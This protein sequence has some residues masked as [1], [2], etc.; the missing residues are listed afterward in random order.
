MTRRVV[1]TGL[2]M[3][4]PLGVTTDESWQGLIA[5]KSGIRTIQR[6]VDEEFAGHKLPVSIGGEVPN[7][8]PEPWLE[9]KKDVKRMDRFILLS[10]CAG[11]QAW[12]QAGLPDRL[13]DVTGNRAGSIVGVGLGGLGNIL[14]AYDNFKEKGPRR[15]SAFFIP[16]IIANLAPGQMAIRY[17][18]RNANWAPASACSSGNHGIGEAF[19]HIRD[20]RADLMLCG[21]AESALEPL[22]VAGFASM[23]ALCTS[24][25]NDPAGSSRPF[26]KTR[27]GF[28]MGEGAGMLVL[29]DLDSAKKRGAKIIAEVAGYGSSDDAN[30]ITAPAP[31]GE[32]A[33]RAIKDALAMAQLNPEQI[34]YVNAHGT[35]TPYND[36]S[37]TDAIKGVF[38]DYA[39][40]LPVSSTK[41]MIG[42]LLGAAG[43]VEAV[44]SILALQHG[45]LPPTINYKEPDPECDL[46]YIPNTAREV[47]VD[48]AISN[49]F[50]FGG[51]NAVLC[52]KQ[53]KG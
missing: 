53:F 51:T 52:F 36:K 23:H 26:D 12:K 6:W 21:G 38:K 18:L 13:D 3:T 25:N 15:V 11:H 48:A 41:S 40:K 1:V 33:Q 7:F 24:K 49:S 27:D 44:I 16:M 2:G 19:M 10:M 43:G 5:G 14:A 46:D 22:A 39:K 29:E 47:R 42:H 9:H 35:S 45:I 31:E 20:G 32:G 50:G 30:H 37:E 17:N 28:V 8:D 34:G 4:T